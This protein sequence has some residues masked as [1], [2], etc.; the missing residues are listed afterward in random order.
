MNWTQNQIKAQIFFF[1]F[2]VCLDLDRACLIRNNVP[3]FECPRVQRELS[4]QP[5][6]AAPCPS[7]PSCKSCTCPTTASS[8]SRRSTRAWAG[9]SSPWSCPD[10]ILSGV[11][12]L[13]SSF[14]T[15]SRRAR[16]W[17]TLSWAES[18]ARFWLECP[19]QATSRDCLPFGSGR[20]RWH[21]RDRI[22]SGQKIRKSRSE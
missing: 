3:G 6:S 2:D 1:L 4:F 20:R 21:H 8:L 5:P 22:L 18:W 19:G 12:A 9:P 17:S 14:E 15:L 16:A 10:P 7:A 11:S 13:P